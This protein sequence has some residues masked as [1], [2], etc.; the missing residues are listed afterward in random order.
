MY[1]KCFKICYNLFIPF[2]F[3]L[4]FENYQNIQRSHRDVF[5]EPVLENIGDTFRDYD[6]GSDL[7]QTP[8]TGV[9][10]TSR[11]VTDQGHDRPWYGAT[12]GVAETISSQRNGSQNY[13]ASKSVNA[14]PRLQATQNIAGRSSSG[15]SSSWKNSEEEEFM[16][17]MHSRL[18]DHDATNISNNSRK[19]R[20]TPDVSE[21][22]VSLQEQDLELDYIVLPNMF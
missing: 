1:V 7:S 17:E 9:G 20:W 3:L 16:W 5:N 13:S 19:D 11:K 12:S 21:K 6:Y 10:R 2:H 15:L 14:D 4:I 8:G 18:S 22:L